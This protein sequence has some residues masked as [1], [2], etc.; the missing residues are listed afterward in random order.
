MN[1]FEAVHNLKATFLILE[2]DVKE[3]QKVANGNTTGFH[4]RMSIRTYSALIEGLLY[5]MRQVALNSEGMDH[6]VY[7]EGERLLLSELEYRLNDKGELKERNVSESQK[8][9]ILFTLKQFPK[10]HGATFS[11]NTSDSGWDSLGKF[12][13]IR[14]RV[15]HPKSK[16]DLVLTQDEWREV[17]KGIDWFYDTIKI[18]FAECSKADDYFRKNFV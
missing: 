14:N 3:I 5:Q 4:V 16:E 6:K 7:S 2:S 15:T 1:R 10:V 11:P 18:L 8:P 17:N 12:I 13:K 9:M